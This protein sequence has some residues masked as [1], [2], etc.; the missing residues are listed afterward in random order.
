MKILVNESDTDSTAAMEFEEPLI[1]PELFCAFCRWGNEE[2][3]LQKREYLFSR[4]NSLGRYIR[5]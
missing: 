3:G 4:L 5:V 2:A 1:V